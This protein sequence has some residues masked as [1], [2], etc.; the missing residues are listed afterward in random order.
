MKYSHP[1]LQFVSVGCGLSILVAGANAQSGNPNAKGDVERYL[2]RKLAENPQDS[3]TWRLLGKLRRQRGDDL[4]AMNALE[5]SVSIDPRNAATH[6][7]LAELYLEQGDLPKSQQHFRKAIQFAPESDYAKRSRNYLGLEDEPAGSDEIALAGYEVSSFRGSQTPFQRS[8]PFEKRTQRAFS[9][10]KDFFVFVETGALYNSNVA[11]SPI[12]RELAPQDSAS[13]QLFV[14]PS[15]EWTAIRHNNLNAGLKTS[16]YFNLNE[17][18]FSAFNL[19]SYQPGLFVERVIESKYSIFIPRLEYDFTHD[20]F[21]GETFGN[22]HALTISA[23]YLW[24]DGDSS[25]LYGTRDYTNFASEGVVPAITSRDG[26]TE[27]FGASHRLNVCWR[28]LQSILVGIDYQ[29]AKLDGSDFAYR[30]VNLFS[31]VDLPLTTS[32]DLILKGGWGYRNYFDFAFTPSRNE[33]IWQAG[34]ELKKKIDEHWYV[35]GVL[36]Y[37]RFDSGNPLFEAERYQ[38]GIIVTWIR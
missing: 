17:S 9:P 32:V 8:S 15:W 25:Y 33:N 27:T 22:R 1:I 3:S 2:E 16:G 34:V 19:Q 36:N 26:W 13:A 37:D 24:N 12:S 35:S 10:T 38:S 28:H 14:A 18:N 6:F 30:G 7:D 29:E 31:E 20:E 21:K 5:I 4:Q 11:L 23:T